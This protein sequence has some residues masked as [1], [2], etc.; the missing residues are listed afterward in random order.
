[1]NRF[2]Q[3]MLSGGLAAGLSLLAVSAN[4][5]ARSGAWTLNAPAG[6]V[7]MTGIDYGLQRFSPL[8]QITTSN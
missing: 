2:T 3:R 6:E 8:K 1:M 7:H 4:A 5:Q